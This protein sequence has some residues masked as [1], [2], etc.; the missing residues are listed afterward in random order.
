LKDVTEA[1]T[2]DA[3]Y[4][5]YLVKQ[6]KM[7]DSMR[8]FENIKLPEKLDYHT[9]TH[10]KAEACEKLSSFRPA[11]LA[12]A[13]RISGITPADI[14]IIQVHLKKQLGKRLTIT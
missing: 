6:Q 9:I 8:N 3:K 13:F 14:T 1:V 11:T 7:I 5:G 2:I 4:E 10:L 12:Q